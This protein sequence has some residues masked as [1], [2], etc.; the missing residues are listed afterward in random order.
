MLALVIGLALVANQVIMAA[1]GVIVPLF[2]KR[3]GVDP[4]LAGS[5]VLC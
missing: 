5:T 1:F 4:A 3:I 2:L